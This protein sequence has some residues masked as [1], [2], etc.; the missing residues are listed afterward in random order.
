MKDFNGGK[1]FDGDHLFLIQQNS[2]IIEWEY[3]KLFGKM[4]FWC[5]VHSGA[6]P[7]W[8]DPLHL[9]YIIN[10]E[11]SIN[12]LNALSEHIPYLYNLVKDISENSESRISRKTDIE[13]WT[14]HNGINVGL[15][16]LF[17]IHY[18]T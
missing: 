6:W 13:Y 1:L 3:P 4:L 2:N 9:Q 18:I 14:Q 12:C 10:G 16:K 5:F 7:K 11:T 8:L 15:H 17:L